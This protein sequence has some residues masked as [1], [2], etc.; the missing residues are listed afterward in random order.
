MRVEQRS[1][2][3][4][5]YHA[6]TQKT[7]SQFF[8]QLFTSAAVFDHTGMPVVP[9]TGLEDAHG[10]GLNFARI[11]EPF[12]RNSIVAHLYIDKPT[13]DAIPKLGSYRACFVMRDP[14][15]IV[16]SWYFHARSPKTENKGAVPLLRAR[17]EGHDFE[18]DMR[19]IIDEVASWGTFEAALSWLHAEHDPRVVVLRY[20][21]LVAD[22]REFIRALF[23]HMD[24]DMSD[25]N[26]S[27]LIDRFTFER[28]TGRKPGEEDV[29]AHMRKGVAGDWANHF[30]P[31]LAE[32]FRQRTVGAVEKLGYAW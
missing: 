7:A 16:V 17:M 2:H 20:E 14:R 28:M 24:I 31:E 26:F 18:T 32:Y 30:T 29:N 13:F 19:A 3:L 25:E 10:V 23:S 15:D 27:A 1:P 4:N 12:P 21:D 11:T 22:N 6:C 8:R 9:Y 5:L